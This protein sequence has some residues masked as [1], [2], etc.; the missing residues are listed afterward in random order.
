MAR[1]RQTTKKFLLQGTSL[2]TLALVLATVGLTLSGMPCA[3]ADA[4]VES[5]PSSLHEPLAEHSEPSPF[6]G[7]VWPASHASTIESPTESLALLSQQIPEQTLE[8]AN[9][10]FDF[11]TAIH[12][13]P[14]S[15]TITSPSRR[16]A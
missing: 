3:Q 5:D 10:I 15:E 6:D 11:F 13:R 4:L 12:L 8:R 9:E 7:R 2:A 16:C 1:H 14:L